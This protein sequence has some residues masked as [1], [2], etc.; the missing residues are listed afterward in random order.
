MSKPQTGNNVCSIEA[1]QLNRELTTFGTDEGPER[2]P[3]GD[4]LTAI[5]NKRF[6]GDEFMA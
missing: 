1:F 2:L 5:T 4:S 3:F 6:T